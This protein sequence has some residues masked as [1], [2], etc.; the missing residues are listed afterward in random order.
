MVSNV[1]L[2][3]QITAALPS[4]NSKMP[5]E[6]ARYQYRCYTLKTHRETPVVALIYHQAAFPH[7]M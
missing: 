4:L 5:Q 7:T 3:Q 2:P 6:H 1:H